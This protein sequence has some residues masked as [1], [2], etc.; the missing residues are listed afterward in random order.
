M[1]RYRAKYKV[2]EV[3]E[4]I[5]VIKFKIESIFS[6]LIMIVYHLIINSAINNIGSTF[7][8][9][10]SY[11]HFRRKYNIKDAIL[12]YENV[13]GKALYAMF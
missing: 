3:I 2:M 7:N 9:I 13:Q 6:V 1:A 4:L 8:F 12:R 10:L 11:L 5:E